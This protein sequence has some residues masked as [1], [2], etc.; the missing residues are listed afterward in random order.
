[1]RKSTVI[2][3]TALGLTLAALG[4]VTVGTSFNSQ[5][6]EAQAGAKTTSVAVIDLNKVFQNLDQQKNWIAS[7]QAANSKIEGEK[8]KKDKEIQALR[9]ELKGMKELG[10][11]TQEI[12]NKIVLKSLELQAW[13]QFEQQKSLR[14]QRL[15]LISLYKTTVERAQRLVDQKG[16][17]MLIVTEPD[18]TLDQLKTEDLQA[19]I[20]NRRMLWHRKSVNISDDLITQMNVEYKAR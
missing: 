9:D 18:Q 10:G 20:G 12:E 7:R 8:A 16:Y 14:L 3:S 5:A 1:M 11:N 19:Y 15:H 17:D 2:L 13:M 6:A 4:G